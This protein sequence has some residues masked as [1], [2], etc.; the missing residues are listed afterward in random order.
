MKSSQW[1]SPTPD[2]MRAQIL[3]KLVRFLTSLN[4][5]VRYAR[6][7]NSSRISRACYAHFS[8][9]PIQA[10]A[11]SQRPGTARYPN[12][13]SPFQLY[14]QLWTSKWRQHSFCFCHF[15]LFGGKKW[16]T[17]LESVTCLRLEMSTWSCGIIRSQW[18]PKNESG[19]ES[20]PFRKQGDR[21]TRKKPRALKGQ[22][23][24]KWN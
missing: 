3:A 11:P 5:R 2:T 19:F 24:S 1:I 12:N 21:W 8:K 14:R 9:L 6:L 15:K 7:E 22:E 16:N 20:H 13:W 18:C 23:L 17:P 4:C 10:Q